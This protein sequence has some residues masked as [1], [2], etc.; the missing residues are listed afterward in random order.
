MRH[1]FSSLM[2]VRLF[3]VVTL[4]LQTVPGVV[5][6]T[7]TPGTTG[8]RDWY[9]GKPIRSITFEGLKSVKSTDLDGVI[10]PYIGK[11][12]TDE[13]FWELQGR[14]Y[15]LEFFD[16]IS[17]SARPADD[18]GS[19]VLLRFT[20]KERP[21]VSKIEFTGN[22]GLKTSELRDLITTKASNV[23][24]QTKLRVDEQALV[25]KYI[26]KGFPDI[27]IRSQTRAN[28]D[29]SVV[30]VFTVT[31]GER[32]T[33]KQINFEGNAQ[34]SSKTLRNQLS[35]TPKGILKD[36]A[37]QEAKLLAD[38][39][40]VAAYYHD[41][42]YIDA[43]V[44]DV[45]RTTERD[46][47]GSQLTLTFKVYEG[48]IFTFEG[49]T[50]EGNKIFSTK[51]LEAL[52]RSQ[53]GKLVN[54]Q[55]LQADLMRVS[56]LY[57][58]NGYINNTITPVEKR[59]M[60]QGTI[61]YV[62]TIVERGRSFVEN[63]I[64]K[65]N[66]K[67]KDQVI[68]REIPLEPGDIFSK[69]RVLD[70]YRNL[71]NLQYFSNL[72]PDTPPGSAEGL[73]DLIINVEEQPT[74][75]IQAGLS[76]SGTSDP[77]AF[78]VSVL[79][80]WTDRNFLGYG[81]IFGV[82]LNAS[83]DLQ[84]G[85]VNYTQRWLFGLPLS[86]SFDFTVQHARR[87]AALDSEAPFFY[88]DEPYAY[89]DGFSSYQDYQANNKISDDQY[90][91]KYQQ[92][93]I[94]M[95]FST[96]YRWRTPLG[97]LGFG[98]GLRVGFKYNDY[99]R[100]LYRPFDRALRERDSWTPATSLSLSASLDQRDI[101][102][103]PSKGYYVS[104]RFGIYGLLP[105][106]VEEEYYLRT[107]SK[108]E[109]FWTLWNWQ[110]SDKWAFK[111][112]LGLHT[113]FSF[114]FAQPGDAAPLIEQA[115]MLAVDGMFVGRGWQ[116]QR[117]VRG[118]ALWENWVE[119]RIPLVPG[120]IALDGFFDAAEVASHASTLFSSDIRGNFS[121]RILFSFGGGLRF[122]IPQFPFRFL[123]AKR[124]KLEDGQVKFMPGAIGGDATSGGVDFVLSFAIS[125]Y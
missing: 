102:Y 8:S 90:L 78:P 23:Y 41:R 40:A 68:L 93:S 120:V 82:E 96:G 124:F 12:Y 15:E 75:D 57:F 38:R 9:Q 109:A 101:F 47:K 112:V 98:G 34:F 61:S 95:G 94:S 107:E 43:D 45:T 117:T 88:G 65:G 104:Q 69:T 56:D 103:D 60:E 100:E 67:T 49:V 37:F 111:G 81:N 92:W 11:K 71:F 125:T 1:K 3:L 89:P 86:G 51:D 50:F 87:A 108:A 85:S 29:G 123:F 54:A 26:E 83:P 20:V 7:G 4:S 110:V 27:K 76:F 97:N 24:N 66:K 80:K 62:I 118:Y 113:G 14:L 77:N 32:V 63:I 19:E 30:V 64:V 106:E 105:N 22:S 5:G 6:Q 59:N 28:K 42:G 91:M 115:N 46:E 119:L 48:R 122:A 25:N 55:R 35:L 39:R 31:E 79:L 58:E 36:G 121:D 17:P 116:N 2:I 21:M 114:L 44:V 73:I 99:A 74:T 13:L 52:I 84:N 33:I 72:L 70:G 18:K 16:Q 10:E 53:R